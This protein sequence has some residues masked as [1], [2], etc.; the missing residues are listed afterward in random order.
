MS[1]DAPPAAFEARDPA[2]VTSQPWFF[3]TLELATVLVLVAIGAWSYVIV[4]GGGERAVL[5]PLTTAALLVAILVPAMLLMV[6]IA[7]RI[8]QGRAARSPAG[9]NGR[10]HVRL[11]AL[12]SG[13]AAV[14]TLLVV[15]FASVLFQQGVQFWYSDSARSTL[16]NAAQLAQTYYNE[17]LENVEAETVTMAEDLRAFLEQGRLESPEFAEF[18]AYQ[19]YARGLSDSTI[20]T[21]NDAGQ[22]QSIALVNPDEVSLEPRLTDSLLALL[23]NDQPSAR[24]DSGGRFEAVARFGGNSEFLIYASRTPD[25][26]MQLQTQRA[27]AVLSDY[28]ELLERARDWQLRFNVALLIGALLIVSVAIV[29]ALNVADRLVRPLNELVDAARKVTAGDL[30]ARVNAPPERDEVGTLANAFNLMTQNLEEQTGALV[31]A[32]DL[33]DSR[34]AFT[35]AVLSSVTAGVVSVD[36]ERTIR[37]IN[38]SAAELLQTD[39]RSP[40]GARLADIAP[41]LDRMLDAAVDHSVIQLASGGEQRT[42]AVTVVTG[43]AGSVLTFDDITQRLFDQRRAA[44]SDVARR[45][46]HEI[47]NPLTP[48]QLA[49]ERLQRRFGATADPDSGVFENLTETIIRQVG[50][51]RRMVDEFSSFARMPKP[52]FREESVT[53]IARQAMFLHEVAHPHIAFALD[54]PDDLLPIVCD[55]RQLGQALT[56]VV[57]NA[58]EAVEQKFGEGIDGG[59]V[60]L[61]A[62]IEGG[63]LE[64]FVDD[65]GVG[66]PEERER[67]TEPYMTTRARGTGLGL[68]IVKKIVEEHFGAIVFA[69]REGGGT[70]VRITLDLE[71]LAPLVGTAAAEDDPDDRLSQL[72][73]HRTDH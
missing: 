37:L 63:R 27:Q 5:S 28:T 49:A 67:L 70:R 11:V 40:I 4:A 32:N 56:N 52:L 44:W 45:I 35:E 6:L 54:V 34:R 9:G 55:R 7:R 15:I 18:Y 61:T 60:T 64:M 65:N 46:A 14:P 1:V 68:A 21:L 72:T 51:L 36:G 12:F 10:L 16:E 33:N 26:A 17:A 38:R 2:P 42:L 59:E 50:D 25:E 66:L 57:K 23:R 58:V 3:P 22:V 29:I 41:E 13:L 48:I 8:A 53:D 39:Q 30:T 73:R 71:T 62:R 24:R 69:D 47:K 20:F 19:V 31:H 43:E